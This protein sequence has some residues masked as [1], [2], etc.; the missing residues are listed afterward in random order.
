MLVFVDGQVLS[1]S[2]VDGA[3]VA[4]SGIGAGLVC[5]NEVAGA[6]GFYLVRF[7]PDRT[8]FWRIVLQHPDLGEVVCEFDSLPSTPQSSGMLTSVMP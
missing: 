2:L 8:G 1:W 3:F 7:F 6:A 5:F 4:D